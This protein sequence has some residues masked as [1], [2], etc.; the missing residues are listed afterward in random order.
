MVKLPRAV[1][2]KLKEKVK[3][4]AEATMMDTLKEILPI[5]GEIRL[6]VINLKCEDGKTREFVALMFGAA[7]KEEKKKETK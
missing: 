1:E 3:E 6:Q 4:K 2:D 7:D 5:I